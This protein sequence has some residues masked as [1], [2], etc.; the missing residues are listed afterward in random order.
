MLLNEVLGIPGMSSV[1]KVCS[2]L[3]VLAQVEINKGKTANVGRTDVGEEIENH[4]DNLRINTYKSRITGL[5]KTF[6]I[7]D[8]DVLD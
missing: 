2:P 8:S 5:A 3:Y 6:Y 7:L 4:P 1:L